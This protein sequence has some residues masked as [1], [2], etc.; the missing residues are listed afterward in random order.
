MELVKRIIFLS[1]V[2]NVFWGLGAYYIPL[3]PPLSQLG[4]EWGKEAFTGPSL[5]RR[6]LRSCRLLAGA[7]RRERE[8]LYVWVGGWLSLWQ[9]FATFLF[10]LSLSL[11][12]RE[13]EDENSQSG[14]G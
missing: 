4:A 3:P 11:S 12:D 2:Y 7:E 14:T 6:S 8:G 13:K 10:S 5:S 1:T 9:L